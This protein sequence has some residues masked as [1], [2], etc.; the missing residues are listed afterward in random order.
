MVE[1]LAALPDPTAYHA[2]YSTELHTELREKT[3]A[4]M[5]KLRELAENCPA[6]IMAALRCKTIPV[7]MVES[8]KYTEEFKDAMDQANQNRRDDGY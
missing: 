2:S 6:C 4:A 3:E 5:P 1:M 8:F 7:P